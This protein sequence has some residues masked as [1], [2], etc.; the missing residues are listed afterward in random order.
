MDALMNCC[1]V[2]ICLSLYFL[3]L[4]IYYSIIEHYFERIDTMYFCMFCIDG[5]E[6]DRAALYS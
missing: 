6:Q 3:L 2:H 4:F 5:V 1:F